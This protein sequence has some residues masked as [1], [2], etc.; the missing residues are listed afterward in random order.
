[1][2]EIRHAE[3]PPQDVSQS[4]I[5]A[6]GAPVAGPVDKVVGDLVQPI[7]QRSAEGIQ[8]LQFGLL[9]RL[10]SVLQ[11]LCPGGCVDDR[12]VLEQLTQVFAVFD[13]L[14]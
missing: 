3:G 11:P 9:R 1:M 10:D 5:E 2:D 13:Q 12:P 14:P 4:M 7:L 8:S 6:L